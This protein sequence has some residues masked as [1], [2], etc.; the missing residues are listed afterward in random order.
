VTASLLYRSPAVYELVMR[1]L[2]RRAYPQRLSLVAAFVA[3]GAS[4]LELC[5]GPGALYYR[6]LRERASHYVA[7]DVNQGF[8]DRLGR[9]GATVICRDLASDTSPL[10]SADVV[11]MQASLYHFLPDAEGIVDRMLAAARSRTII[12]EPI[13]NLST[14]HLA[15]IAWLGRRTTNPGT[16]DG[17]ARRFDEGTL[18][19]L[20]TSS[21][22]R[23]AAAILIPGG[24]EKIFVLDPQAR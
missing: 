10:P 18:D 4:V 20:I 2:Y 23:V 15:P 3:P 14:S 11:I 5:P 8:L 1:A 22:A 7:I 19:A 16:G 21:G 24:R 6:H 17:H 12:A 9:D 13:R